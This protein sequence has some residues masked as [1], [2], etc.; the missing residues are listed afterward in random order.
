MNRTNLLA[1][2]GLLISLIG[3]AVSLWRLEAGMISTL[4]V[5]FVLVLLFAVMHRYLV[6]TV[7]RLSKFLVEIRNTTREIKDAGPVVSDSSLAAPTTEWV[8]DKNS[9]GKKLKSR[10]PKS[11]SKVSSKADPAIGIRDAAS[12]IEYVGSAH[13]A[14]VGALEKFALRNRSRL[15]RDSLAF[16]ASGLSGGV[17]SIVGKLENCESGD[18][19]ARLAVEK[20]NW[21]TLAALARV[22]SNQRFDDEDLS[23]AEYLYT[24]FFMLG[25]DSL[26][27]SKDLTLF[28]E[29]LEQN[30]KQERAIALC[31]KLPQR[32][33]APFQLELTVANGLSENQQDPDQ[34]IRYV[35]AIYN[36]KGFAGLGLRDRSKGLS[37]D[38]LVSI[39]PEPRTVDGP[40]ISVLVPTFEG[41]SRLETTLRSLTSQSWRDLEVIVVDDGSSEQCLA[42][43][44][45][46]CSKYDDVILLQQEQNLGAYPA[47]NRGLE[48]ARGTYVTVHDDDDWSHP[49]K[50]EIQA[51]YL[52]N[53]PEVKACVSRHTRVTEGL[54]FTRINSNPK[55][56][57]PNYSSLMFERDL[58][59][60]VGH[61]HG[62]NRGADE[63]FKKRLENFGGTK[64][65]TVCP[66]PLSFTRTHAASLT[67]GEIQRGYQ[68][69]SR[70]FY[71]ASFT[72]AHRELDSDNL[73]SIQEIVVP[74]NMQAGMRKRNLGHFDV[75]VATDF[76]INDFRQFKMLKDLQTAAEN[77]L[78]VA[79]INLFA[80]LPGANGTPT[81]ETLMLAEHQ[82]VEIVSLK[83]SASVS[84]LIVAEPS[85]LQF[86]ENLVSHLNIDSVKILWHE[87]V[88]EHKRKFYDPVTVNGN[89][90]RLFGTAPITSYNLPNGRKW[91]GA[92]PR[93]LTPA[94]TRMQRENPV[95]GRFANQKISMWPAQLAD[96]KKIYSHSPSVS[97]ALFGNIPMLS[98][99]A[100]EV[101]EGASFIDEKSSTFSEYLSRI[102][103]WVAFGDDKGF[104]LIDGVLEALAAGKVVILPR[105][106]R[107]TFGRSAIY[108]SPSKV[109]EVVHRLWRDKFLYEEQVRR[110]RTFVEEMWSEEELLRELRHSEISAIDI[111]GTEGL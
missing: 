8:G 102:D 90:E 23:L 91:A 3:I 59:D 16:S 83:D 53:H 82:N 99:K 105:K 96:I 94:A 79:L 29:V 38:N 20:W 58:I 84:S 92:L 95:I 109:E 77:G 19:E 63:E 17:S 65:A 97:V 66:L 9:E 57:Q 10:K 45:R 41:S 1:V 35:S 50:L 14:S 62:I 32:M 89:I 6:K 33:K 24:S 60:Q 49:Q 54:S 13:Q 31:R 48:I 101:L 86:G 106:Y 11:D 69:P 75:A 39:I 67:A 36:R 61:W 26:L 76:S 72:R 42:E 4:L 18:A 81:D 93:N 100:R 103:F 78:R 44:Q 85:V 28:S 15:I 46:I 74:L 7:G 98:D 87:D 55:F 25:K 21:N 108:T 2:G 104:C 56:I 12:P 27:E 80:P 64:V 70:L 110:G 68:D 40:K 51:N 34:W 30:G 111:N 22:V 71:H 47:R 43:L 88:V 73:E 5:L 52:I 37:I 107:K